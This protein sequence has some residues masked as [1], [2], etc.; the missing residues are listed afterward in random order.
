LLK[1][2]LNELAIIG[3]GHTDLPFAFYKGIPNE[4]FQ[5]IVDF[6]EHLKN[7]PN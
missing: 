6:I 5:E 3:L 1:I 7:N 2:S 4:Q